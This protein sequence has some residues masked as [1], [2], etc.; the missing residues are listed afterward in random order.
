ML[1]TIAIITL[2]LLSYRLGQSSSTIEN[3]IANPYVIHNV[4]EVENVNSTLGISIWFD[5][6]L[7][8][9][10]CFIDWGTVKAGFNYTLEI[11]VKNEGPEDITLSLET[12]DWEP[13]NASTWITL[14][15]SYDN[16]TLG[17]NDVFNAVLTL[18]IDEDIEGIETFEF[19]IAITASNGST[20]IVDDPA[21]LS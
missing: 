21:S 17:P 1:S 10:C 5:E 3:N 6:D 8:Q 19:D 13:S 2:S 4:G 18:A 12:V 11:Y 7:T 14:S 16:E 9:P 15:W 20:K